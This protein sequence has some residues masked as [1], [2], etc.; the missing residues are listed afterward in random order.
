MSW[1]L[2]LSSVSRQ[3]H[4]TGEEIGLVSRVRGA[5]YHSEEEKMV[6]AAHIVHSQE[7]GDECCSSAHSPALHTAQD[8]SPGN[9]GF[10]V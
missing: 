3:E 7:A 5:I 2:F 8:P 1:F 6:G 9:S 4:L 10:P